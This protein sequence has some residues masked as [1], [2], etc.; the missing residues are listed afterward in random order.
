MTSP[1]KIALLGTGLLGKAIAEL[2]KQADELKG[3]LDDLR[4]LIAGN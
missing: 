4:A 1:L 3:K 2:H